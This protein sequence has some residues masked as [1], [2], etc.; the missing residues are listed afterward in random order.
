[1]GLYQVTM[2]ITV[3]IFMMLAMGLNIITGYT[4]QVSLGHAAF[5][6]IGAYTS[7]LLSVK[8]GVSFWLAL[9]AA[10]IV[11]AAIGAILGAIH[12]LA[13][14]FPGNHDNRYQLRSSL[15]ISVHAVL[16]RSIGSRGH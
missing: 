10:A 4:G 11:T 16:R 5:F 1:M 3:G 12:T 13:R 14:R 15:G 8:A 2:A 7:A 9:P 6:G